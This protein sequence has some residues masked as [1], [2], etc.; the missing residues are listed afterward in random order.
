VTLARTR[1]TTPGFTL[2]AVSLAAFLA[3]FLV[4]PPAVL[5]SAM[6]LALLLVGAVVT[7]RGLPPLEARVTLPDVVGWGTA[8][9]SALELGAVDGRE[10]PA[11]RD[12][13]ISLALRDQSPRPVAILPQ[14]SVDL[15][16]RPTLRMFE[17]GRVRSWRLVVESSWPFG[18]LTRSVEA[19]GTAD[20]LVLPR[21]GRVRGFETLLRRA[22][23]RHV[24]RRRPTKGDEDLKALRDWREGDSR[25]RIHWKISARRGRDVL[26]ELEEPNETSVH[27]VF[28]ARTGTARRRRPTVSF[29]RAVR[30]TAS[31]IESFRKS[32]RPWAFTVLDDEGATP[33]PS[34]GRRGSRLALEVLAEVQAVP[35][36]V[37]SPLPVPARGRHELLVLVCAGRPSGEE[38]L[39]E[40]PD[41]VLDIESDETRTWLRD[42]CGWSEE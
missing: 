18:L 15:T 20:L 19:D 5:F 28:D 38:R 41:L 1:L 17:R 37:S 26:R 4:G 39:A 8:F 33:V 27:L 42:S 32:G 23:R 16:M 3:A 21:I 31:L 10:R 9:P 2:A 7:I 12:V 25:R 24:V 11:A 6:L 40:S 13:I 35:G 36:G 14:T 30:L 34:R 22:D 29:E